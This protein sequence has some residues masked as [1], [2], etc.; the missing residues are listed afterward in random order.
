MACPSERSSSLSSCWYRRLEG[1]WIV[2]TTAR[3]PAASWH[4][5]VTRFM[6]VVESSPVPHQQ[7]PLLAS[8]LRSASTSMRHASVRV[9]RCPSHAL[10]VSCIVRIVRAQMPLATLKG[11]PDA[12]SD[13]PILTE[14]SAAPAGSLGDLYGLLQ[15]TGNIHCSLFRQANTNEQ[16]RATDLR[17]VHPGG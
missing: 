1:W 16:Q 7:E 10:S 3:P 12:D 15:F 14:R 11:P 6:A 13:T 9:M 2:V 4:S 8:R 5:D 17:W